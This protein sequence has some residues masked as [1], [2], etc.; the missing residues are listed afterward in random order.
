MPIVGEIEVNVQLTK[1]ECGKCGGVYAIAEWHREW[2]YKYGK[3]WTCPYCKVGWGYSETEVDR[4]KR[5]L[6]SEERK[7]KTAQSAARHA[8]YRRRAEKAAKT[9]AQRR[10]ASGTCPCCKRSFKALRQHMSRKHPEYLK[11]HGLPVEK[12][13]APKGEG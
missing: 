13:T 5:R 12:T 2:C 7:K 8:E 6:A 9:R 4:L 10:H 11:E 1:I 3:S